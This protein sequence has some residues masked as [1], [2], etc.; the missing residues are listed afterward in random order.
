MKIKVLEYFI[1]L[2]EAKSINEAAQ[3]LYITQPNL[4]KALQLFEKEIGVSLFC[5]AQSGITLTE[6]GKKILPEAKQIMEYYDGWL[7]LAE[8]DFLRTVDVYAH[9]SLSGFLFPDIILHFKE[10]YSDLNINYTTVPCPEA[11]L[12]H[13]IRKPVIALAI[14][15]EGETCKAHQNIGGKGYEQLPLLQGEYGCLVNK[16]GPLAKRRSIA[17]EEL[18]TH[19]YFI[20]P[21]LQEMVEKP[22]FMSTVLQDTVNTIS[23]H[24]MVQVETVSNVIELLQKY[25]EG[26]VIACY[27]ACNRYAGVASGDLIYI[28]LQ[29]YEAKVN[30]C[31]FYEKQAYH[32]YPVLRELIKTITDASARFM[33]EHRSRF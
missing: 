22:G 31:L 10:I 2:A 8:Q 19:Y 23:S 30:I 1:T 9:T 26:Y 13:D 27:P 28:P 32:Q 7:N 14:C 4:T 5:R 3:K 15:E 33:E 12:S 17:L 25:P 29:G 11:Y 24:K 16:N 21:N 18:K 20:A 6:A